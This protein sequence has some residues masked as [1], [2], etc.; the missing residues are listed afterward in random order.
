MTKTILTLSAFYLSWLTLSAQ[1]TDSTAQSNKPLNAVNSI[2]Y[3]QDETRK[4]TIGA[5]AQVEFTQQFG[6]TLRHNALID[7]HRLVMF[8]GYKF[9]SRTHFVSEIE[10]EHVNEAAVE[11]AFL[12]YKV[13]RWM[14]VRAGLILI[15]MGIINEYHEPS[16]FNG[17]LRPSLDN[18]IV[19]TTWRELGAGVTGHLDKLAIKY[20]LYAVNGFSGYDGGGKFK[21][22]DGLRGGRQKG[23]KSYMTSP[24]ISAKLD[25]YGVQGL[26]IGAAGYFGES[27]S[28]LFEGLWESA[29]TQNAAFKADSSVV[30]ITM[31][32]F[33][34][35]YEWKGLEARAQ[36]VMANL[37]NT[38]Q[39]NA[40]TKKD[41]G[42]A[43]NGYYIEAGYNVL[44]CCKKTKNR[45]TVF[46]RYENYNTHAAVEEGTTKNDAYNRTDITVGAGFKVAEGAVFKADYQLLSNA[47]QGSRDKN[48]FNM[49]IGIWF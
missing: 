23:I 22:D 10:F 45:L 27:E 9:N 25:Y 48:L 35:R 34:V 41:L 15:P 47:K 24:D 7:V 18:K 5:Y 12:N 16:T 46:G 28:K 36:Y 21:G 20:Q 4:L 14:D 17:T 19:P 3:S 49:G 31:L 42:S 33:D 8:M 44:Q 2:V 13:T 6:D 1:Q 11:Q 43:M 37:A 38:Q 40:L 30:G 32:G 29:P 39:Y 26:K